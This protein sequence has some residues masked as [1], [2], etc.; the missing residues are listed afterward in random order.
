LHPPPA[1]G[2]RGDSPAA[3]PIAG[4]S[5]LDALFVSARRVPA[6]TAIRR[7]PDALTY[8]GLRREIEGR[9]ESIARS[10]DWVRL[11]AADP[12]SFAV[13]FFAS[14]LAA[15]GAIAHGAQIPRLLRER[16]EAHLRRW[17]PARGSATTVFF[18][19]GSVG[20]GK[21]VPLGERELLAAAFGYPDPPEIDPADRV[22]VGV[23]V[24]HVFGFVRGTL[25]PL[26][27]GAEIVYYAPRRDPLGE[28]EALGGTV[29]LLPGPLVALAGRTSRTAG[30]KA[31]FTGGGS[32]TEE[33]VAA[34]EARRGVPV[35]LGYGLTESAGLGSRQRLALP[36]RAGT[37]GLPAPGLAVSIVDAET[38]AELPPGRAGIIRLSGAAVFDGY[39]DDGA[40]RP[41]DARGRLDTGDL[42][43]FDAEGELVVRGRREFS[44]VTQGRTLCA[45]EI[46]SVIAEHPRISDVAVSPHG[47][48]FAVLFVAREG[49]AALDSDIRAF[50][51]ERLPPYAR[52]RK[53]VSVGELPR[54]ASG[55]LD[56]KIIASWLR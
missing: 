23:S 7:G 46:E 17:R 45:E 55:K 42:G 28:A 47:D 39:A 2:G 41:F 51:Q 26:S 12:V 34:V 16:R 27:V 1:D 54:N 43:Y 14:R 5:I 53:V 3:P 50:L 29:A 38:G 9:A 56:R 6:R 21:P 11:D 20:D 37:S 30:L 36:R 35:R 49:A 33:T 32:L 22:A 4:G 31:I 48:S 18:S 19:S 52:P 13:D 24:A 25:H 40:P 15:R 10:D 8:D 44:I